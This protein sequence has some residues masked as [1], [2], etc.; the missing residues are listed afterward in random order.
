MYEDASGGVRSFKGWREDRKKKQIRSD[1]KER[2]RNEMLQGTW[3]LC[4]GL[5][6]YWYYFPRAV[7]YSSWVLYLFFKN[8]VYVAFPYRG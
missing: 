8:S 2:K 7:W 6:D 5:C 1:I 4:H 3:C